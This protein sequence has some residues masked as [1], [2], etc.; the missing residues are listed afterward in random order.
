MSTFQ[1]SRLL[2]LAGASPDYPSEHLH[3]APILGVCAH[4]GHTE[5]VALFIEF[6]ADVNLANS[7]GV[8]ALGMA[9]AQ[10]HCDVVRLLVQA[11]ASLTSKDKQNNTPMVQAAAAGHLN[12]VGY[13]LSCDWPGPSDLLR[14][15]SHQALVAAASNGHINVRIINYCSLL[16][17]VTFLVQKS[18][19]S[20]SRE[21][22]YIYMNTVTHHRDQ[23]WCRVVY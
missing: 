8:T 16:V 12:V 20:S 13:L 23:V 7:E 4:Q 6:G 2:L 21:Y 9:S 18:S 11:G 10:G 3:N 1:V 22:L 5:M 17:T 15:Q 14:N 19:I